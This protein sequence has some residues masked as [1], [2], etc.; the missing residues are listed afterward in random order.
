MLLTL[1][2]GWP[3]SIPSSH[4]VQGPCQPPFEGR[5]KGAA[6]QL[7]WGSTCLKFAAAVFALEMS[8]RKPRQVPSM[9]RTSCFRNLAVSRPDQNREV[10]VLLL[11]SLSCMPV[12]PF[13][14]SQG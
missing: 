2:Q 8:S 7:G 9:G 11:L 4:Q 10:L 14:T 5:E 6:A 12:S 1:S 13:R 3:L